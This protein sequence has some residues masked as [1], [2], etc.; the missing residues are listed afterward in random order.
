MVAEQ[1]GGPS[2]DGSWLTVGAA[3]RRL[4]ISP[5]AV[6]GRIARGTL[7]WRPLGNTGREVLVPDAEASRDGTGDTSRDVVGD[8]PGDAMELALLREELVE[9]LVGMAR[10]EERAAALRELADRLTAELLEARRPWWR[11]WWG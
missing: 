1:S 10:A 9:A 2:G 11:R 8:D 6:R 5:R 7:A 3:A 4:G